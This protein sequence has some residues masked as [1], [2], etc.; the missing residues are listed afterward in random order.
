VYGCGGGAGGGVG[1]GIGN[2][3]VFGY[4]ASMARREMEECY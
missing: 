2:K 3:P 4:K 1:L